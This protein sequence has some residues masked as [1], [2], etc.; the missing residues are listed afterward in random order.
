MPEDIIGILEV[1]YYLI[2]FWL[3]IFNR[4]FRKKWL[5]EFIEG[6]CSNRLGMVVGSNKFRILRSGPSRSFGVLAGLLI[7]Y[8]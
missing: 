4:Q 8:V 1:F 7:F 5:K 2:G 3:F 6:G